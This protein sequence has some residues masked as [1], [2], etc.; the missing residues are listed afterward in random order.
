MKKIIF[1]ILV[2]CLFFSNQ[3]YCQTPDHINH[4]NQSTPDRYNESTPDILILNNQ[5]HSFD[6][7]LNPLYKESSEPL[8]TANTESIKTESSLREQKATG[9][10]LSEVSRDNPGNKGLS[11]TPNLYNFGE[12]SV[13]SS[14][15]NKSFTL[16]NTS[17]TSV[18]GLIELWKGDHFSIVSGGGNFSLSH[19]ESRTIVVVFFPQAEGGHTDYLDVIIGNNVITEAYIEGI[20][21]PPC[22]GP[23]NP[24]I[25]NFGEVPV[26]SNSIN[27]TFTFTNMGNSSLSGVIELRQGIHFTIISGGGQYTL[28][29]EATKTIVVRFNPL[30]AGRK[31]DFLDVFMGDK[32][33]VFSSI[34]GTGTESGVST[35]I[36][37]P[38]SLS[39][40]SISV[41]DN[42]EPQSYL[43]EWSDLTDNIIVSSN[44]S[45][46]TVSLNKYGEYTSSVIVLTDNENRI[47]ETRES[48]QIQLITDQTVLQSSMINEA[49]GFYDSRTV[50][51]RFAEVEVN[52]TVK[53]INYIRE[54]DRLMLNLFENTEYPS[55]VM[56]VYQNING[57]TVVTAKLDEFDYA[58]AIS[59]TTGVRS[60]VTVYIPELLKYYQVISDPASSVHYV[61]EMN[62]YDRD[63]LPDSPALIPELITPADI[64]E[65][66]RIMKELESRDS[67]VNDP[68]NIDVM[69]VYTPAAQSWANSSGG[70]I[71]NVVAQSMAFAQLVLD[72]SQTITSVTLVHSSPVDYSESG[73]SE[74]DLVRLTAS[75]DF[76]PWGD[77]YE[78]YA[79]SGFMDEVHEWRNIYGADLC[80]LFS[81]AD[82][83]GGLAWLLNNPNGLPNSGFSLTRVQQAGISYTHIHEMGH[84]MGLDHHKQQ[85]FQPGP[86]L[87]LYSAGWRWQAGGAWYNSVMAYSQGYYYDPPAPGAG[88]TSTEVPYFS[89]PSVTYLGVAT[90]HAAD[91]DNAR[92][93]RETK[94][95]V[96]AYSTG[97]SEYQALIWVR[98]E[99]DTI[100]IINCA[101]NNYS[102]GV[103]AN[104]N[105]TGTGTGGENIMLIRNAN[106]QINNIV[107]IELEIINEDGFVGFN[108]DIPLPEG[109]TYVPE[110]AQLYRDD[111]HFLNFSIVE[112]NVARMLSA[113][114]PTK[115]FICNNGVVVSF[116]VQTPNE[117][118]DFELCVENAAIVGKIGE[119]IMTGSL[120]GTISLDLGTTVTF[121]VTNNFGDDIDDAIVTLNGVANPPGEYVFVNIEPEIYLYTVVNECYTGVQGLVEVPDTDVLVETV[122]HNRPGDANNDGIVNVSDI[123]IIINYIFEQDPDPFC[124]INADMNGDG[125]INVSDVVGVINIFMGKET[126]CITD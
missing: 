29:P 76:N 22:P 10:E 36:T 2:T 5:L 103:S 115:P 78:G 69:I 120:C 65:Q 79:V 85:N 19:G 1:C 89:N 42:S 108:A 50:A 116:D 8:L 30:A 49:L 113:S 66:I 74:V 104:V 56:D 58:Y 114:I 38:G 31:T 124:F 111:G 82:D 35:I 91:G 125:V 48:V 119:N 92:N 96:A 112:D 33:F 73:N 45:H 99:P 14:S 37:I 107:T 118:D 40:G 62:S 41:V 17:G 6:Q 77:S 27:Q 98:F 80:A 117:A 126:A 55:T 7:E 52:D 93:V 32:S 12:V 16:T 11:L 53:S 121:S 60:L 61:V 97:T 75:P 88:I 28:A 4:N 25:H 86:G 63:V 95:V 59:T 100:G 24:V 57:T 47:N 102:S 54:N 23:L 13:G 101:I 70:G 26:G 105:V 21:I 83:T 94:H 72:N 90:G 43:L 20:G 9:R 84:N 64:K 71:E 67:G 39:F 44:S 106:A 81:F 46:F 122:L 87:F 18:T 51:L 15:S 3:P 110:S 109:F 68:A 123:V 34:S